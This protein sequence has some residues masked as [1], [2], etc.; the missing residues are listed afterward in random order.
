MKSY[1]VTWGPGNG[2]V[3][4]KA[5]NEFKKLIHLIDCACI[6]ERTHLL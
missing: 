2:T 6:L 3:I 1:Q 5:L 4:D